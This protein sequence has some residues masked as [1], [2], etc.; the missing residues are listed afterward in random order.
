[1]K[2]I[3]SANMKCRTCEWRGKLSECGNIEHKDGSLD[4]P[5]CHDIC[6]MDWEREKLEVVSGLVFTLSKSVG[7]PPAFID[8][9]DK[10]FWNTV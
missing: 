2:S 4:C 8:L 5:Q 9:I 3:G 6:K 10:K 1:M 7:V